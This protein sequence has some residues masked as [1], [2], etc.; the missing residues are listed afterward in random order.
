MKKIL[1]SLAIVAS[2]AACQM[3]H[4][5]EDAKTEKDTSK[6]E[7]YHCVKI[8][9]EDSIPTSNGDLLMADCKKGDTLMIKRVTCDEAKEYVANHCKDVKSTK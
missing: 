1:L 5:K 7:S 8:E 6:V 3:H 2:L 9:G 4:K